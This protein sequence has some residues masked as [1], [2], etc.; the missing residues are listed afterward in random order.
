MN[1]KALLLKLE[2]LF[3]VPEV[4][5]GF[6]SQEAC[7]DWANKVAPLLKFNQ[8]YYINFSQNA[9]KM[10]L[11]LS[12]YSLEP[13]FKVMVSQL[14]MAIEELR[15]D[16][17]PDSQNDTD[18]STDDYY[19]DKSR[20]QEL[21][22]ISTKFDLSKLTKILEEMNVCSQKQCYISLITLTR[23]L[24]DHVPPVFSCSKFSEVSNNYRGNK[25]FKDSML[26]LENSSRKI[27]DQHLHS[28]IRQKE[29]LPNKTQVNFSN[30]IDVLL[31]E[32]VRI[33]K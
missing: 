31:S 11:P 24:L 6:P 26:H 20:I 7:I 2:E 30:D 10:N 3:G 25:S 22:S 32:I 12:S 13:A 4:R 8:Q 18:L 23:A 1:K 16:I 14:Q 28:Q 21:K 15:V 27:A 19:V 5:E 9:H 33:L 17:E 29:S